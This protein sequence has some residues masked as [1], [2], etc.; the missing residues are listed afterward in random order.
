MRS[1][2]RKAPILLFGL[3]LV[4]AAFWASAAPQRAMLPQTAGMT[5]NCYIDLD[6]GEFKPVEFAGVGQYIDIP[7]GEG[8]PLIVE[9]GE[10]YRD[11]S[12]RTTVPLHIQSI[13][14]RGFAEGIGETHFWLDASRP[15][16]SAIWEKRP[17]TEFP[18]IQEMRFHFFYTLEAM[19][20]RVFRSV[21]P[22]RMRSDNVRAFPPPPGTV[23]RLVQ[24]V[25]LEDID[26]PGLVVGR[27][28]ANR[29]VMPKPRNENAGSPERP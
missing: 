20:G 29:V 7:T 18:A 8:V 22:A 21:N 27:V 28:L 2:V 13:G 26:E 10:P 3:T 4:G 11:K 19:P 9:T 16:T 23:Y 12:G 25:E 24:P 15:L 5:K 6:G 1:L 17:G 14:A